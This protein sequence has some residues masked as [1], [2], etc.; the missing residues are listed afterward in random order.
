MTLDTQQTRFVDALL[1]GSGHVVLTGKAGTGKS[2]ALCA[3]VKA[4]LQKQMDV[5]VMAP[6]AMAASIHRDAGLE[7][8]TVHHALKWNPAREPL[9]RKL[10]A[11]CCS[12]TDWAA[13]P[14]RDRVLIVDESSMVGL[15]LF[16]IL[17]RDLGN[18]RRP[19]DGRRLVLV[20]D[21]AQL[22]PVVGN[23]E[24]LMAKAMPEL[25]K[26]GPPDGC[27]LYHQFFKHQKGRV[28]S[29]VL[30]E[31]HRANS[32]WFEKLNALRDLAAPS[33]L[34]RIG[35]SFASETPDME[36]AV[37]LCFRHS[38]AH[39]RN[40]AKL[41]RLPG[42]EIL[43]T[44]RDGD[45]ALKTGCEVIVTSNRA[46]GNYINGSR[47]VFSGL[48]AKGNVLLDDGVPIRMLADGNWGY[49]SGGS[50][51]GDPET[52]RLKARR[53]LA[54][55]KE[56]LEPDAREWLEKLLGDKGSELAAKFGAGRIQFQ[57]YFPIL[58][59]YAITVHKAQGSSLSGAVIEDDVFWSC[60]P[61]RL[62]YVALSRVA[63][64]SQIFMAM[65]VSAARVRPDPAYGP[66]FS[67][68]KAWSA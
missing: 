46:G 40:T 29:V 2:T 47:A 59:G 14:D 45:M 54:L 20:G 19:F 21:W 24:T 10:L 42:R 63:D 61:A 3:A 57:P 49:A 31:T 39:A 38:S 8:G 4:A 15:W 9:P 66:I 22:P 62:P 44:L 37:H 64:E 27:V 55:C 1:H 28:E 18:P 30:E 65:G 11:V 33:S 26:F 35:M 51:S 12:D 68:I 53:I 52:G 36:D 13:E 16:E 25:S 34:D 7:S 58:P 32:E 56:I 60:A 67:R 48:D 23:D 50:Q 43:L 41:A 5:L 6:T 17:A